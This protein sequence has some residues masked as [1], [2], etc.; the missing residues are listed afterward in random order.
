MER[1]CIVEWC[2]GKR[3]Y[4]KNGLVKLK[5]GYCDMHYR[6]FKKR[7]LAWWPSKEHI[8]WGIC[9]IYGCNR[10]YVGNGYCRKHWY[11]KGLYWDPLISLQSD[12]RPAVIDWDIA[13][14]PLWV[15][16][17]DWYAIVDKEFAYLDRYN[18][19]VSMGYCTRKK[20]KWMS[21]EKIHHA[22]IWKPPQWLVTDHIN[23]D[24]LDNR[25][26][27]LRHCTISDNIINTG[28]WK[29]NTTW[30]KWISKTG[31]W[32]YHAYI[33]NIGKRINLWLYK[34]INDAI[35]ARMQWE[36]K[37]WKFI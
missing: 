31:S 7:S 13:K 20:S 16:A 12:H 5:N 22:I 6:R 8:Y 23:R 19:H 34:D 10:K 28:L 21:N 4:L 27:N 29:N 1:K 25:K 11:R 18:R 2:E 37:Y 26:E 32:A 36:L 15:N 14:I 30:C 17:K 24:K 3:H 9:I 35:A 33:N